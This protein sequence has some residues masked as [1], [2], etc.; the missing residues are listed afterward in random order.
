MRM[1]GRLMPCF[2][3]CLVVGLPASCW[4]AAPSQPLLIVA[5]ENF[6]GDVAHQLAGPGVRVVSILKNPDADPHLFEPDAATARLVADANILIYNGAHYDTWLERLLANSGRHA[7]RVLSVAALMGRTGTGVNPHLWYD[8]QTMPRL[9]LALATQLDA[10]D[11][12]A[13]EQQAARLQAF[14]QSLQPIAAQVARMRRLY[15]GAPITATE[16]VV[17]ALTGAIGLDMRNGAFQLSVMNDTEPGPRETAQF[18]QSLR[19]HTVRL[20]I[21]N[22]QTSGQA[23][24]RLLQV[25]TQSSIPLVAVSETEPSGLNYQAW[26]LQTLAALNQALAEKHR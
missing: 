11:P 4:A 5:A 24:Q 13:H 19:S 2:V 25:A 10:L 15:A 22:R 16:P 14:L 9:A 20:L 17:D 1:P 6:Y 23:V 3:A 7:R 21:Y 26:M 8:P 12:T 18:E